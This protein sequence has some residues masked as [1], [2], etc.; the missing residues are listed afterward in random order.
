MPNRQTHT[1][2]GGLVGLL[3]NLQTRDEHQNAMEAVVGVIA[4]IAG[5]ILPDTLEPAENWNHRSHFHSVFAG[6]AITAALIKAD[7]PRIPRLIQVGLK[8]FCLGY[9]SHLAMDA[10]TPMGLPAL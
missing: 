10:T 2:A 7:D 4:G 5:G 6:G 1:I 8:S 9:L 3:P